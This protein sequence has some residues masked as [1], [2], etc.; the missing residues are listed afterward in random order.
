MARHPKSIADSIRPE[1]IPEHLR[2]DAAKKLVPAPLG[3]QDAAARRFLAGAQA[4]GFGLDNLWGTIDRT[5]HEPSVREVAL[6]LIG[7]GR[8]AMVFVSTPADTS[9]LS[10][11]SRTERAA[12]AEAATEHLDPDLV[13]LA[14]GLPEP[15]DRWAIDAFRDAGFLHVGELAYL[16][17]DLRTGRKPPSRPVRWPE[18]IVVRPVQDLS[19]ASPDRHRLAHVLEHSYRD[20]LDCP[21]LCGLRDTEDVIESHLATG[22]FDPARWMLAF[23]G[24]QAVGCILIS[25]IPDTGSAELVY[26]GLAP[27]ARGRGL[28]AA[29]LTDSINRLAD[30]PAQSL[31]CAV[32]RRNAPALRLYKGLGFAEFSSRDAWVKP[33]THHGPRNVH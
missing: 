13:A 16:R 27:E 33:I 1:R 21:E 17:L 32:D 11:Q 3:E 15:S 25:L 2:L 4:A 18:G 5:G 9:R 28:G 12:C 24:A 14:Q 23:D 7:P 19:P 6:A 26:I 8:T 30:S 20:T 22:E 29:L 10:E 31:V